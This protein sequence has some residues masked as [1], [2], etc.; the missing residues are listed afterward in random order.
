[1]L[2]LFLA[3]EGGQEADSVKIP[4]R[5]RARQLAEGREEIPM[6][7]NMV[8]GRS[9]LHL[10]GP[11]DE[12]GTAD[13]SLVEVAFVAPQASVGIEVVGHVAAL[14]VRAIV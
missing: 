14:P 8:T 9:C 7:G 3:E 6:G 12:K 10:A 11:A 13:A 2:F 5:F 4:G 1:M